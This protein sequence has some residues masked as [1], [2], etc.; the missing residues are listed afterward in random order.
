MLLAVIVAAII[1][2]LPI[3]ATV[4]VSVASK[5][6]D[7][8]GTLGGPAEGGIQ[9]AARRVLDFHSDIHWHPATGAQVPVGQ[10]VYAPAGE[11]IEEADEPA[12]LVATSA[13]V[14]RPAA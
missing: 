3:I 7:A 12:I 13:L 11:V 4:V 6:E 9:S 1:V 5:R 14:L 2:S 10:P 8:A